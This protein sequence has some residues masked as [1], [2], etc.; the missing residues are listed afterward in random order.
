M[1]TKA[2]SASTIIAYINIDNVIAASPSR[3]DSRELYRPIM[4]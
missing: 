4:S 1:A 2:A 3:T